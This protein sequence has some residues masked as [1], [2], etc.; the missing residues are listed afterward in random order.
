MCPTC[1]PAVK[2]PTPVMGSF[3]LREQILSWVANERRVPHSLP[4][5]RELSKVLPNQHPRNPRRGKKENDR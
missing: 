1:E 5:A 4:L 3:P 2:N